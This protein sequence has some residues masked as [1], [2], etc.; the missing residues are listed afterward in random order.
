MSISSYDELNIRPN[1][2]RSEPYKEYFS[3]MSISDKEKQ[4]RIA[5]SEQME[6]VVLYILALIETTIESG[7]SDQE[8]I[9]TQ[10]YDKYLDVIASYMLIDTYIKQYALD[11]TKQIIDATFERFSAEDKSITDDY[12]LSNDRTMFISECEANSILNYRQYSKAVKAGKT[13]KKW[14]DVGDKRERKTHL[15]VGGT[16]LPID[17]PFSVGDSLLQFPK[18]TS[19]GASADE[20]VN[21]RCSIQ[22]S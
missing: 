14:I 12:Y 2:R 5:F 6:E 22:Y 13:K 15:E 21:C 17:E 19:L 4:Q 18:D 8:Y 20:V 1:N 9:Q 11:V 16:I 10:F 3:K 7:E